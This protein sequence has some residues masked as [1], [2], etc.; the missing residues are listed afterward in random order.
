MLK[1]HP[2]RFGVDYDQMFGKGKGS[3]RLQRPPPTLQPAEL[4][5]RK[6]SVSAEVC[7]PPN[8]HIKFP[9]PGSDVPP[10]SLR[11]GIFIALGYPASFE[12]TRAGFFPAASPLRRRK[13]LASQHRYH[14][15]RRTA[16]P[17][18]ERKRVVYI[19]ELRDRHRWERRGANMNEV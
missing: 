10:G 5:K 16:P 15:H 4:V 7:G 3:A 9:P 14:P 6:D 19:H 1:A 2:A 12:R 17:G 13:I 18:H 8:L 11:Q